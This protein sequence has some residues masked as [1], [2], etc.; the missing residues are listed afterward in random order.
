MEDMEPN[1]Y[2]LE[3]LLLYLE[4]KLSDKESQ[5]ISSRLLNS[6]D[7]LN[8][9]LELAKIKSYTEVETNKISFSIIKDQCIS[10]FEGA[11]EFLEEKELSFRGQEQMNCYKYSFFD[12]IITLVRNHDNL[13][14]I[15]IDSQN[16]DSSY[17]IT[18]DKGQSMNKKNN[19]NTQCIQFPISGTY[20]L[21]LKE[22]SV[23]KILEVNI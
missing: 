18:D 12:L 20:Y 8:Y 21:L 15:Y 17:T 22:Q 1:K 5:I 2:N 14:E 6:E 4:N 9:I 23:T 10:F 13:W 11:V 7:E 19:D 16:S 3:K